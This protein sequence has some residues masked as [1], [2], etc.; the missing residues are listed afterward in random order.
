MNQQA[1]TKNKIKKIKKWRLKDFSLPTVQLDLG[2]HTL[3]LL[4]Y[5][6]PLTKINKLISREQNIDKNNLIHS[7]E[8]WLEFNSQ[9]NSRI[10]ISK[11]KIGQR[12]NLNI[13]IYG[14]TGSL[15]WEHVNPEILVFFD[16]N[17]KKSV[18]DRND[19]ILLNS[20]DPIVNRYSVG[21]PYGFIES[22]ANYYQNIHQD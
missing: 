2:V 20:Q 6:Q 19:S 7:V 12:N 9:L 1:M 21:H 18:L 5:F 4:N 14:D 15:Y 3:C 17:G 13:K 11:Y 22:M 8:T 16:N 10:T